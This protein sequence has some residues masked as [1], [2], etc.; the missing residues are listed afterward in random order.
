MGWSSMFL[1]TS[2]N[3]RGISLSLCCKT[4]CASVYKTHSLPPTSIGSRSTIQPELL[5]IEATK[6]WICIFSSETLQILARIDECSLTEYFSFMPWF[7]FLPDWEM[8]GDYPVRGARNHSSVWSQDIKRRNA[9]YA[10]FTTAM[11]CVGGQE[12]RV[13]IHLLTVNKWPIATPMGADKT[14]SWNWWRWR[15]KKKLIGND[16]GENLLFFF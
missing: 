9:P 1:L 11:T 6:Y 15:Q 5:Q 3:S 12:T 10:R 13:Q 8:P 4:I 2:S 7:S 16:M 14:T